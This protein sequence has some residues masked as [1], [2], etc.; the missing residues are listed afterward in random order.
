M[1]DGVIAA[2]IGVI[3][4]IITHVLVSLDTRQKMINTLK[5]QS[6]ATDTEIEKKLAVYSA[7]TD[8]KLESLTAEIR[9]H[10]HFAKRVPILETKMEIVEKKLQI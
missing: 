3:G 6:V 8:E 2:L 5:E 9:E 1:S 4:T 7:K 10:N